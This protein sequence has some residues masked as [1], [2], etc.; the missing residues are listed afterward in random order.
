MGPPIEHLGGV[1]GDVPATRNYEPRSK[2][3]G[4]GKHYEE[5]L[6][7]EDADNGV[8]AASAPGATAAAGNLRRGRVG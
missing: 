6:P 1:N 3:D 2:L 7:D 8:V 5:E 4:V